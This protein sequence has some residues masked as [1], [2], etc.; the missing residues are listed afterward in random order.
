MI[1]NKLKTWDRD[2]KW[3]N[4][5]GTHLLWK[6]EGTL[7]KLDIFWQDKKEAVRLK[8]IGPREDQDFMFDGLTNK[9]FNKVQDRVGNLCMRAMHPPIDPE[10]D[11]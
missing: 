7:I 9:T 6:W 3:E 1:A 4:G 10:I 11:E 2:R 8:F 5:E